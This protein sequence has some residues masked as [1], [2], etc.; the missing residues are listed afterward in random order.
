MNNYNYT[1]FYLS[2]LMGIFLM[3]GITCGLEFGFPSWK[4]FSFGFYGIFIYLLTSCF[5]KEKNK[6]AVR[7]W[8]RCPMNKYLKLTLIYMAGLISFIIVETHI[9]AY[10]IFTFFY[11]GILLKFYN[12]DERDALHA[13]V[14][15]EDKK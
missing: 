10:L 12:W 15:T 11:F 3:F 6:F 4:F 7:C 9:F 5:I 13:K 1:N 8:G 2:M 14:E